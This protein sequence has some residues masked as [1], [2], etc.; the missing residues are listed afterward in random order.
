MM[1]F[2]E[3]VL[4]VLLVFLIGFGVQKWKQIDI[5]AVSTV[6][7]YIMTPCLVFRTFYTAELD[8]QYLYIIFFSAILLVVLI[9]INKIYCKLKNY[10]QSIES[11]MIL[12]T[13]FMNTGNYGAPI[14]LFAYGEVGFAYSIIIL[15]LHA[16]MMNF[17]GVY[18]AARGK[19]GI[20][21]ALKSV[22]E[23]PAT[24]AVVVAIIMKGL[25]WEIPNNLFLTI[26]IVAEAAVPT[27]MVILGL[28][29]AQIKWENFNWGHITYGVIVRLLISPLLAVG[30][31]MLFPFDP[32]LA[33]VLIVSSAMPSAATIVIYAIQ[34]NSEPKLVSSITLVS[35]LVSIFTITLLLAILG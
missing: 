21:V 23:M 24:W 2:I 17:F 28:Q 20:R 31:V 19:A 29:L 10:P 30:I 5:K 12:S 7:I 33:K 9:I 26:D 15:V 25:N 8:M 4:P 13:A 1:I 18:Y 32:L 35:T 3:V 27:V 16:I 11:G 14:I 6:A 22:L 34:F